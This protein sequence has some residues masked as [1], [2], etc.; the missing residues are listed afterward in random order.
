MTEDFAIL[1]VYS[2]I[3]KDEKVYN[4]ATLYSMTYGYTFDIFISEED[5]LFLDQLSHDQLIAF[6]LTN[7]LSKVVV[8][9]TPRVILKL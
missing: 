7:K 1:R 8:N 9:N 5:Y 4:M 2:R 3:S 6:D